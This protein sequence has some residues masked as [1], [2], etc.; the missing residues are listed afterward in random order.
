M[1]EL[2][3][4]KPED[5]TIDVV[6]WN[7]YAIDAEKT[8]ESISIVDDE[9][10]AMAVD[11]LSRV[12]S[13]QKETEAARITHVDPFNQ[14]VKRVNGVFKPIATSLENAEKTIKDK[15]KFY[16][17][18]KER[19][20][21][22]EE[23]RRLKEYEDKAMADREAARAKGEIAPIVAPPPAILPAAQTTHGE[24]GAATASKFW[25]FEVTDIHAL[26][27]AR[28]DL[29]TLEVK[30]RETLV[31]IGKTQTI[32]GLRIFEDIRVSAR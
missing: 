28:P 31:A 5:L 6:K 4:M 15:V 7:A 10:E 29:V 18:E 9:E 16:R 26:Y 32:P 30:K 19:I 24:V 21:Q 17:T 12:K 8:A 3:V 20:R 22:A 13:F 1:N 23:A 2:A 27:T 25:N 14:L 11:Y